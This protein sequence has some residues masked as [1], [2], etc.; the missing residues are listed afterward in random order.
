MA[1]PVT[2]LSEPETFTISSGQSLSAGV[3]LGGRI[4][5]GVFMPASW[6][7]AGL[8]FQGSPDGA[9]WYDIHDTAAEVSVAAAAAIYVAFDPVKFYGINHMK[10]RSGTSGTPVNQGADRSLILMLGKPDVED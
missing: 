1:N 6:T 3:N 4:P 7:A 10:V 5:V 2:Q 9:T 8:T